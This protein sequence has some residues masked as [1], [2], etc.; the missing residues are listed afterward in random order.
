MDAPAAWQLARDSLLGG[1]AHA[2]SNRAATLGALAAFVDAGE[3]P[4]AL[5]ATLGSETARLEEL[6]QLAR[7]LAGEAEEAPE[8]IH[9]PSLLEGVVSV[10]RHHRDLRQIRCEIEEGGSVYPVRA[11]RAPLL[12][13]LLLYLAVGACRAAAAGRDR[14]RLRYEGDQSWVRL[15]IDAPA[16]T[17]MPGARGAPLALDAIT[18]DHVRA[19]VVPE[20]GEVEQ[21]D[22]GDAELRL[23]TLLELRRREGERRE[24]LGAGSG[25]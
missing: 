5:G 19:L 1:L 7:A 15:R 6:T 24:A 9:V 14:V 2:L 11:G 17:A 25:R 16:A 13:A 22:G 10:H 18:L 8:A 3:P 4:A 20:G 23:P 12:R 21:L